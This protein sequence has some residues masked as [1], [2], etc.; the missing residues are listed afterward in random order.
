[1]PVMSGKEALQIMTDHDS[2]AKI[3]LLTTVGDQ[4]EIMKYLDTGADYYIRKDNPSDKIKAH[5]ESQLA[6]IRDN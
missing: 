2:D 1:M 4:H 6:D 5:L 3:I